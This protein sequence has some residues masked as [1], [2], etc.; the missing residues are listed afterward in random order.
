MNQNMG[1]LI[2]NKQ[3]N[4]RIP[5]SQVLDIRNTVQVIVKCWR[6]AEETLRKKVYNIYPGKGEVFITE[7]FHGIFAEMLERASK[8]RAIEYAFLAD[9]QVAFPKIGHELEIL[10]SG[11]IADVTLHGQGTEPSTG[12]DLGIMLIRPQVS[13]NGSCLS[14]SD[15]RRGL[16]CQAK[17]RNKEGKWG[18]FTENQRKVLPSKISY[19]SLLLYS[20]S[21]EERR[22]LEPFLWQICENSELE[23]IAG[24]LTKGKFPD[25]CISDCMLNKLAYG[26]VGT[27]DEAVLDKIICPEG[28]TALT[29]RIDWPSGKRPD[30]TI[31]YVPS[32]E[33]IYSHVHVR[34]N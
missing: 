3:M 34:G 12:G 11:L 8:S 7:Y 15:C 31:V 22:R 9:L 24:W 28:N 19:L 5:W 29:I 30:D 10:S 33:N 13:D 27:D 25:A 16:L 18:Q 26:R 2:K 32:K 21:D 23:D 4:M 17:L 20:Y 14:I 6:N 1:L